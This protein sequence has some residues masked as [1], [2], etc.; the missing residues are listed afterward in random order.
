MGDSVSLCF[1]FVTLGK[2]M[3]EVGDMGWVERGM[4]EGDLQQLHDPRR[5]PKM[6]SGSQ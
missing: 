2:E 6:E 4:E 3:G 5:I 1:A